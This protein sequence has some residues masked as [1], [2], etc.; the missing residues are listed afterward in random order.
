MYNIYV[1]KKLLN[2]Y[3]FYD[4][5]DFLFNGILDGIQTDLFNFFPNLFIVRLYL[6]NLKKFIHKNIKW[7]EN[8]N[9]QNKLT[10]FENITKTIQFNIDNTFYLGFASFTDDYL[11]PD[12]DICMFKY[13]PFHRVVLPYIYTINEINCTC[14]MCWLTK[15]YYLYKQKITSD[16]QYVFFEYDDTNFENKIHCCNKCNFQRLLNNCDIE[17]VYNKYHFHTVID[18]DYYYNGICLSL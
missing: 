7:I 1:D 18:Y 15:Y 2:A 14:T 4:I 10:L 12:D 3:L 6:S 5:T 9:S 11:Y 17:S 16:N 13:F 8:L